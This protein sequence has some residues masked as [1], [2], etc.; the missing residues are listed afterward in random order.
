[1]SEP[2][3]AS[4]KDSLPGHIYEDDRN[5]FTHFSAEPN[6]FPR[7]SAQIPNIP[8]LTR[9]ALTA[10]EHTA[11][12]YERT[13]TPAPY[14]PGHF[15][16][17][18]S[19]GSGSLISPISSIDLEKSLAQENASRKP[20]RDPE[21]AINHAM[22]ETN[23]QTAISHAATMTYFEDDG[24]DSRGVQEKHAVKILFFLSGPCVVLSTINTVWTCISLIITLLSQPVRLCARRLTFGQQLGSLLGPALNLQLR[25]I[26][27]PL[28][29]HANED[30]SYHTLMLVAVHM[31]NPFLSLVLMFVAWVFAAY[32]V[33]SLV[34][35]DPAGM[36]KRDD[37][38][39]AV[40]SLR[41]W[42]EMWLMRGVKEE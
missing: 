41:K 35:G 33:V 3:L 31:I 6:N 21:K 9:A 36:D 1:M 13:S 32:W 7:P 16:S 30:A 24:D 42:W 14:I 19:D 10:D 8:C 25:C 23:Q 22:G 4:R 11:V 28:Q 18:S 17:M 5:Q 26:H 12:R 40:L 34:L 37:G 15:G 20:R 38:R 27:M 39:D 29:P 2:A